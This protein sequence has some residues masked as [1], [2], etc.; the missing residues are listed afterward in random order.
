MAS[1]RVCRDPG[2]RQRERVRPGPYWSDER[3]HRAPPRRPRERRRSRAGTA[4]DGATQRYRSAVNQWRFERCRDHP[5][6][7]GRTW[8]RL[9]RRRCRNGGARIA[10]RRV[11]AKDGRAP[12]RPS[13]QG[14]RGYSPPPLVT[15]PDLCLPPRGCAASHR[16][17]QGP[18]GSAPVAQ[19]SGWPNPLAGKNTS[20]KSGWHRSLQPPVRCTPLR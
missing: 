16:V 7:D 15:R 1:G 2:W 6:H 5:G 20:A 4:R 18:A 3:P 12:A 14:S 8:Y 17:Q 19:P 13:W 10:G 9:G 11:G